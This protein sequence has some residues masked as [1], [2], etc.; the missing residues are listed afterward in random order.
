VP[1]IQYLAY[2]HNAIDQIRGEA[3]T[4]KFFSKGQFTNPMVV[5]V[6]SFAYQRGFGGH[7]HND[8]SLGAL[9]D[10]PGLILAAP[11]RGDDAVGMLRTCAAAASQH[12]CVSLF[13]EPIALHMQKDRHEKGDGLWQ[14]P[15]PPP[16]DTVP[17]GRAR[18]YD[19]KEEDRLTILSYAN[20]LHLSL[21][22]QHELQE[23]GLPTRVV[24]LRW[25]A[26]LPWGDIHTHARATGRV[27][28]VDECRCTGGGPS[29]LIL[30]T[31]VHEGLE[32]SRV[33]SADTFVPLGPAMDKV[34][35][36]V[37]DIVDA[38]KQLASRGRRRVK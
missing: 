18:V 22:A 27:L 20:G 1:E 33:C 6:A 11:S 31:L 10:I 23:Q 9:L 3:A 15:Y 12:G 29:A 16:E 4:L 28:V 19:P 14:F 25:L 36:Q 7:F 26:P 34:L 35:V 13:L 30:S 21:K 17:L 32:L 37:P 38:A 5:R 24:D 2:I 8:N